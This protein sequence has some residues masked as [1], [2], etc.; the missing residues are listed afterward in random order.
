LW[1]TWPELESSQ[2]VSNDKLWLALDEQIHQAIFDGL[3]VILTTWRYPAWSNTNTR[4]TN[5]PPDHEDATFY[6]PDDV[7][8]S[9]PWA[10]F[11]ERL[12]IRYNPANPANGGTYIHC[13]EL[14]NEPNLQ[15]RPKLDRAKKIAKMMQT[16]SVVKNRTGLANFWPVLLAPGS[17]DTR[18]ANDVWEPYDSFTTYLLNELQAL[19]ALSAGPWFGLSHHN[20]KDIELDAGIGN[21]PPSGQPGNPQNS[22]AK[23]RSLLKDRWYGWNSTSSA[24]PKV[25]LTEGGAR[26]DVIRDYWFTAGGTPSPDT[27]RN[28]QRELLER[29][30]NRMRNTSD[31]TGISL[32]MWH[33][34]T[35]DYTY[36][37]G[38]RDP[39]VYG[40]QDKIV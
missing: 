18:Q 38:L 11:I 14:M 29:N 12:I 40:R 27:I 36:D 2:G 3:V 31:G 5:V 20:H 15:M 25:L 22:A 35:S 23:V 26:L 7:G 4:P 16:G 9:G 34:F 28:K 32:L 33:L 10:S 17:A 8:P 37:T 19:N 39:Y 30:Y 13:L 6:I 1:A 21:A 24:D